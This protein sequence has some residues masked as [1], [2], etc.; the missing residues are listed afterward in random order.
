M[1]YKKQELP[2]LREH[3]GPP[4]VFYGVHVTNRFS[5][6]CFVLFCFECLPPI[7]CASKV[8]SVSGLSILDC[9]FGFLLP[10]FRLFVYHKTKCDECE[11]TTDVQTSYVMILYI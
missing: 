8:T 6:Q 7:S 3:L 1:S 11:E 9:P 2:T 5:F 10:L 4:T